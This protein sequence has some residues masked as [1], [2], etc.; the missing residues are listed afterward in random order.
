M[1]RILCSMREKSKVETLVHGNRTASGLIFDPHPDFALQKRTVFR[2]K[3]SRQ[4]NPFFSGQI[5]TLA[6]HFSGQWLPS[7]LTCTVE[8]DV[9]NHYPSGAS[10]PM[11]AL[12]PV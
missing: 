11:Q 1:L 7:N 5:T 4:F 2:L 6:V 3:I 12:V 10:T 8:L 9:T